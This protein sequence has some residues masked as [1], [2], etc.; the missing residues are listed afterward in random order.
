[1]REKGRTRILFD[2]KKINLI[3]SLKLGIFYFSGNHLFFLL[4][5]IKLLFADL[6][7]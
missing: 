2:F 6:K 5:I 1:M 4:C 7:I 3:I